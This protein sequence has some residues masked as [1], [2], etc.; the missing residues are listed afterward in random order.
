MSEMEPPLA[1]TNNNY[2]PAPETTCNTDLAQSVFLDVA[3]TQIEAPQALTNN[4]YSPAPETTCNTELAESVF[5]DVATTQIEAP[6]ALTNNNCSPAPET[7]C[8]TE[9]AE[10]VF[11]DVAMTQI[12]APQALTNNNCS[13]APETTCNTDLAGSVFVDFI[14]QTPVESTTINTAN[15]TLYSIDCNGTSVAI[16]ILY[17]LSCV[18]Q[19]EELLNDGAVFFLSDS[20]SIVSNEQVPS[21]VVANCVTE[22]AVAISETT[23]CEKVVCRKRPRCEQL[24]AK[25]R[26]KHLRSSGKEYVTLSGKVVPAKVFNYSSAPCCKSNCVEKILKKERE[27]IHRS[28]WQLGSHDAQSTY[29]AGCVGQKSIAQKRI[30]SDANN[31]AL[32]GSGK[33]KSFEKVFSRVYTL[34]TSGIRVK[35]CKKFFLKT[36]GISNGR[37]HRVL[38][39]QR[40]NGGVP[41]GDKRGRYEHTHQQLPR[42]LIDEVE[43]HIRSFPTNMSHYTRT[44]SASRL[45]L[46]P[47]LNISKMYKLYKDKCKANSQE[48]VKESMY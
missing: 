17:D 15:A 22:P 25:N 6:Q 26:R 31:A 11:L 16:P 43:V 9:L 41:Q 30:S 20:S 45:F 4:N 46:S 37:V 12:E 47:S 18:S 23:L 39:N 19:Y 1:V 14:D 3:T 28:F 8:N 42:N 13:P 33:R 40:V 32:R 44:H 27:G 34:P 35:V 36:L 10:S 2:S 48:H 5:V 7:T 38:F 29:I 24:W 21:T